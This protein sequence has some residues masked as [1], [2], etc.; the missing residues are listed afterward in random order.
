MAIPTF[1]AVSPSTGDPGG[2]Q[3]V[4]ITG[5]NFRYQTA[6]PTLN[7][8]PVS[9]TAS[10]VFDGNPAEE[11]WVMSDTLIL[12]RVPEYLGDPTQIPR[13]E[14]TSTSRL[15][16]PAV[17]IVIQNL[18]N[19]GTII[20][21]ETVTGTQVYTYQQPLIRAPEG[22][23]PLMQVMREFFHLLQRQVVSSVAQQTHTDYAENGETISAL[24][25]FPAINLRMNI[26]R[27]PEYSQYDNEKI[28]VPNG[29]EFIEYDAPKTYMLVCPM[30]I[31][32]KNYSVFQHMVSECLDVCMATPWLTV[33]PDPDWPI[34]TPNRYP[35]EMP[36]FP[37]QIGSANRTNIYAAAASA[38]I[39]GIPIVRADP[40]TSRILKI[41]TVSLVSTALS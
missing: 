41:S 30:V 11:V 31:S 4:E 10:I 12:A 17:D 8:Q 6:D 28:L 23:P 27:D 38:R 19:D 29:D 26:L 25:E 7:P 22:D 16:F 33:Q 32:A 21:G 13:F 36:E 3:V 40:L 20:S 35:L 24:S 37:S 34:Q 1:T 39:R 14:D 5:T 2:G 9:H 15:S 18:S